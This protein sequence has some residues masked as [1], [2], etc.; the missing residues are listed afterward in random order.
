MGCPFK[1][2]LVSSKWILVLVSLLA[3]PICAT[4]HL[5]LGQRQP[6]ARIIMHS[7]QQCWYT[8][9]LK[10]MLFFLLDNLFHLLY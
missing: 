2:A 9:S 10:D 4:T 6:E 8:S 1:F 7:G 5:N 3:P